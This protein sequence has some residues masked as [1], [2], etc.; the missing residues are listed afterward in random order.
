MKSTIRA[1]YPGGLR[2]SA[3]GSHLKT[4]AGIKYVL[5]F[6]LVPLIP[7][8]IAFAQ[9]PNTLP[10]AHEFASPIPAPYSMEVCRDT[11][12]LSNLHTKHLYACNTTPTLLDSIQTD[13]RRIVGIACAEGALW[14][15]V[16]SATGDSAS[17]A[18]Y[19]IHRIDQ[20]TG[21]TRE[22][23]SFITDDKIGS[24]PFLRGMTY[25]RGRF[26]VSYHGGWGPCVYVIN[27]SS[28]AMEAELCC[29][30]PLGMTVIG[31]T[32][33]MVDGGGVGISSVLQTTLDVELQQKNLWYAVPFRAVDIAYDGSHIWATDSSRSMIVRMASRHDLAVAGLISYQANTNRIRVQTGGNATMTGAWG[34]LRARRKWSVDLCTVQGRRVR[35][36]SPDG[37]GDWATAGAARPGGTYIV[38]LHG[39]GAGSAVLRA[40]LVR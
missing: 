14:V 29:L 3:V 33:W 4:V 20:Q 40:L 10:V 34:D 9:P 16:D 5:A 7:P 8:R 15:C 28:R 23:I 36:V 32:L 37:A 12:W 39:A 17:H 26:L 19:A 27:P 30:H 18:K 38:R 11:L 1:A 2:G 21:E 13:F 25:Y 31:D 24:E 22:T 35:G 6:F